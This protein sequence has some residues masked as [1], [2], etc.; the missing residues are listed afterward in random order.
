MD[1]YNI[2]IINDFAYINGGN[3]SVAIT[4]AVELSK[5]GHN[6]IYFTSVGEVCKELKDSNIDVIKINQEDILN[7]PNRIE[8][9]VN[10]I[11][12][13]KAY[14]TLL[15]VL[16]K[17][18]KNKTI[19]HIHG[20]SKAL[21]AS[22][23]KACMK[24]DINTVITAHDYFSF[25]PN[26]GV[27]NYKKNKICDVHPMSLKC[28]ITNC[29]SRCY[30]YKIW[31]YVRGIVQKDICG[32]PNKNTNYITIG[33][34][35]SKI[36]SD[37][38]VNKKIFY[39]PNPVDV[40]KEKRVLAEENNLYLYIGR[41]SAEKGIYNFI[42][43]TEK[44]NLNSVIIGDG[45]LRKDIE[46]SHNIK[47]TGWLS[48]SEI[49]EY[50]NKARVLVF[51]S[52]WYEGLPLTILEVQSKGIPVIVS[53]QCNGRE[54]VCDDINGFIYDSNNTDQLC[55]MITKTYDDNKI[56]TLSENSYAM[57][58]KKPYSLK[59]HIDLLEKVYEEII[60]SGEQKY[61]SNRL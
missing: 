45:Y 20:L 18:D 44:L 5:R 33:K 61:E 55:A 17:L 52:L 43:A 59:R 6:V 26:G 46:Q 35:N 54:L 19:V 7:N 4:S 30:A 12:N 57:Y 53:K 23:F 13:N 56:R 16:Q 47:V 10:G 22:V 41:L 25:C 9:I 34:T 1:K 29:D 31:R 37:N 32:L 21:S 51:P 15:K 48:K 27:Y 14:R 40:D 39:V 24:C 38:V 8:A 50:I 11:W 2:I 58:W 28:L 60:N 3:A 36:M 42:R 49:Q